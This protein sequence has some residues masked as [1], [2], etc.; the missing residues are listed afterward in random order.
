MWGSWHCG[1]AVGHVVTL[2]SHRQESP[3]ASALAGQ[4]GLMS[5]WLL[6][7]ESGGDLTSIHNPVL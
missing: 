6:G 7:A 3:L 5:E 2:V 4:D 1:G